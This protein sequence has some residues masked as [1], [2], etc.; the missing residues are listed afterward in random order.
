MDREREKVHSFNIRTDI[1]VIITDYKIQ[2]N[3]IISRVSAEIKP[4]T[5]IQNDT[6]L[7]LTVINALKIKQKIWWNKYNKGRK[8]LKLN[9]TQTTKCRSIRYGALK[10]TI[11]S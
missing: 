6:K 2:P 9:V 1:K 8:V 3:F 7:I 11:K 10:A 4:I 5:S